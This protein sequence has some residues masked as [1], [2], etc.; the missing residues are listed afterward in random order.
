VEH[1]D[2]GAGRSIPVHAGLG[3]SNR[4]FDREFFSRAGKDSAKIAGLG[5]ICG[6]VLSNV[7]I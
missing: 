6:D 2:G 4:E 5:L 3:F 1:R 7:G